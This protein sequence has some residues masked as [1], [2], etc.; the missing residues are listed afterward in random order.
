MMGFMKQSAW[1]Y[2]VSCLSFWK[3]V[4]RGELHFLHAHPI[5]NIE[6]E[7]QEGVTT[8]TFFRSIF[9]GGPIHLEIM[10]SM[11]KKSMMLTSKWLWLWCVIQKRKNNFDLN[12]VGAVT[13]PLE[14]RSTR[15][16]TRNP[17]LR[18]WSSF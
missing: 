12:L 15:H 11:L 13:G 10:I 2:F 16:N 6:E 7:I 8:P 4:V 5:K 1:L 14:L 18:G 9:V 3:G 17:E